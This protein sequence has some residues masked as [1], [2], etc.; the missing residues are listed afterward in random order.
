MTYPPIYQPI[1]VYGEALLKNEP[2]FL[3]TQATETMAV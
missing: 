1:D 2:K 3:F